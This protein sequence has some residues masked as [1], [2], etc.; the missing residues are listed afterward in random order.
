FSSVVMFPSFR[1]VEVVANE[2]TPRVSRK[3]VTKPSPS[4]KAQRP[5]LVEVVPAVSVMAPSLRRGRG[6]GNRALRA[7]S[8]QRRVVNDATGESKLKGVRAM[9]DLTE[10]TDALERTRAQT[11][12]YFE[13]SEQDLAKP[14]GPGKWRARYILRHLADRES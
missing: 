1:A 9:K 11:L 12:E 13:L 8:R 4:R 3:S 14:Y 5:G 2:P 10:L 7:R 6:C